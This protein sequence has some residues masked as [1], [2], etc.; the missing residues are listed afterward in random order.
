MSEKLVTETE[1]NAAVEGLKRLSASLPL[2]IKP[3]FP[4][5]HHLVKGLMML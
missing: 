4:R 2:T 5:P 3:P 1:Q